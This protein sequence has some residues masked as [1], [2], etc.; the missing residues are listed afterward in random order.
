METTNT[1]GLYAQQTKRIFNTV[2]I[3]FVRFALEWIES[4]EPARSE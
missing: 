1:C 4:Y 3:D 2:R